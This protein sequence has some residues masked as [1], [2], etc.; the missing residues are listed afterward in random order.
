MNLSEMESN[1]LLNG[2]A[3]IV[4]ISQINKSSKFLKSVLSEDDFK[5]LQ[6]EY[7]IDYSEIELSMGL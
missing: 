6:S 4:S 2:D 1:L 3:A 7:N 5:L